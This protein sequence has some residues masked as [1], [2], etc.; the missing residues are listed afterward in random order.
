MARLSLA[1]SEDLSRTSAVDNGGG[2]RHVDQ[3]AGPPSANVYIT[4]N[5]NSSTV[6]VNPG[7]AAPSSSL[8]TPPHSPARLRTGF[9][10]PRFPASPATAAMRAARRAPL[11]VP[12]SAPPSPIARDMQAAP[13]AEAASAAPAPPQ[14]AY[15]TTSPAPGADSP[16]ATVHISLEQQSGVV[17]QPW[18][19]DC[20]CQ[21]TAAYYSTR[22]DI[23]VV[24]LNTSNQRS[25]GARNGTS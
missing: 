9:P 12:V 7:A 21:S 15:S 20:K 11:R 18:N 10:P 4:I 5:A 24:Q 22:A 3:R 25:R 2:P 23:R 19:D 6:V 17:P 16:L 13:L 1:P 8:S 14:D